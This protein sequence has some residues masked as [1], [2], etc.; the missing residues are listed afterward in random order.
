MGTGDLSGV[1]E[2][3][4]KGM[5][6]LDKLQEGALGWWGLPFAWPSLS[7]SALVSLL[8]TP[9]PSHLHTFDIP[10]GLGTGCVCLHP[11]VVEG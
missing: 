8:F 4:F 9:L 10:G 3:W 1:G 11:V 2:T 6:V 7:F 5:G